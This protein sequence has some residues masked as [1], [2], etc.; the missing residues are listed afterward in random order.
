[1]YGARLHP[2]SE[3]LGKKSCTYPASRG[4]SHV[5]H[6]RGAQP[7][8]KRSRSQA[9]MSARKRHLIFCHV[10]CRNGA[11][12][13]PSLPLFSCFSRGHMELGAR[14]QTPGEITHS[15]PGCSLCSGA[16]VEIR[17]R[18]LSQILQRGPTAPSCIT[19]RKNTQQLQ[20]AQKLSGS[21]KVL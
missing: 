11:E 5:Q 14:E 3:P 4:K 19:A 13:L 2:S 8:P 1:M 17:P 21:T 10:C 6:L 16:D 9:E 12:K 15:T 7:A 20:T 18:V